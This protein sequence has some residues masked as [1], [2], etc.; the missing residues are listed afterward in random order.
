[1]G[2]D[3]VTIIIWNSEGEIIV[4]TTVSNDEKPTYQF[5]TMILLPIRS[6]TESL[7]LFGLD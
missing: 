5:F 3:N 7:S 4:N 6:V 1:M 2:V